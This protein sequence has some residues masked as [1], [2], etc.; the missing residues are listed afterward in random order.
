[1]QGPSEFGIAG[2]L[3]NWDRKKEIKSLIVP[4]LSIGGEYDTMDPKHMA[5]IA[6]QV[7]NGSYLYCKN[8]SHMS[9]YDDQRTY[10]RGL[11]RFITSVNKGLKKVE[12]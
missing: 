9:M 8:G 2:K 5:W 1:M 10:M 4:T 6:T 11:S 12:L 7:Q 3:T